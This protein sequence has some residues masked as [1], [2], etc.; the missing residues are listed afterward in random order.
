MTHEVITGVDE[1]HH[2]GEVEKKM[3]ND[4][5]F[6]KYILSYEK[7]LIISDSVPGHFNQS[8]GICTLLSEE[9]EMEFSIVEMKWKVKVLRSL[10]KIIGRKLCNNLSKKV[11]MDS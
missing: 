10:F 1:E 11:K 9:I 2:I 3:K 4:I 8:I 7:A 6:N 5:F